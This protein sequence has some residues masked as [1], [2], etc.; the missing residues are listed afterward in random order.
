MK[1]KEVRF[2]KTIN[3][4]KIFINKYYNKLDLDFIIKILEFSNPDKEK[5]SSYFTDSSLSIDILNNIH[6]LKYKS[7]VRKFPHPRSKETIVNLSKIRGSQAFME[8]AEAFKIEKI[9]E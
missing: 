7:Q 6:F 8:Y 5:N 1:D 2:I 9:F 4:K 3:N